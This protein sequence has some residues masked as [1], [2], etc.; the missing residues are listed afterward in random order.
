MARPTI[1]NIIGIAD[2]APV[3]TW[4]VNITGG[5][6]TPSGTAINFRAESTDIPVITNQKI[7][8]QIR[9]HKIFQPGI[10]EYSN[11]I[12]LTMVE[13][14]DSLVQAWINAWREACWL[15]KDGI[16]EPKADTDA[17]TI[18]QTMDRKNAVLQTYTLYG[19]F[20]ESNTQPLMDGSTSDVIKPVL[21]IS[22]DYFTQV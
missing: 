13:T 8:I 15:V 19:C 20:L 14:V 5:I 7:P 10:T 2:F 18:L 17:V 4:D 22:Y 12:A 3:Y 16:A 1:N 11:V 6:G 21:N 9:G